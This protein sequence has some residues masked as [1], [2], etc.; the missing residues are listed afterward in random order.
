MIPVPTLVLPRFSP[1]PAKTF[2]PPVGLYEATPP[3]GPRAPT[4]IACPAIEA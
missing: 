4:T 1:P 2:T 3:L